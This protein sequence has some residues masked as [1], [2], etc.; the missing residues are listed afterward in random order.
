VSRRAVVADNS[1]YIPG[2][3]VMDLG[4]RFEH[5]LGDSKFTW[6]AGVDNIFNRRAWRESP[7]QFDH[8]YLYPLAARTFRASIDVSL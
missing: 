5:K 6:R 2:Y 4:A 1:V 7:Y 3:G 8:V